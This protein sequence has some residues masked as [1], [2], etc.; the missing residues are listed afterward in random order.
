MQTTPRFV[1][2]GSSN[3]ILSNGAAFIHSL[4]LTS[5][6]GAASLSVYASASSTVSSVTQN[7]LFMSVNP[8]SGPR[9]INMDLGGSLWP[10]GITVSCNGVGAMAVLMVSN[11][12]GGQ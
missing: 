6:S 9:S 4:V 3:V 10:T 8:A 5:K 7:R 12:T 1:K 2:A 11:R